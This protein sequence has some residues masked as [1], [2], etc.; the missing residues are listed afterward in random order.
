MK[1][2]SGVLQEIITQGLGEIEIDGEPA[3]GSEEQS[4]VP[5]DPPNP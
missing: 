2:N 1:I 4:L 3:D 5:A